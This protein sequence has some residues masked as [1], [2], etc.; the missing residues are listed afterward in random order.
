MRDHNSATKTLTKP[1]VRLLVPNS[2]RGLSTDATLLTECLQELGFIVVKQSVKAWSEEKTV[3]SHRYA[4]FKSLLP[5]SISHFL[6]SLQLSLHGFAAKKVDLQIHLESIAVEH[7]SAG[8]QN[9]LIPNQ[10]WVRPQHLCFLEHFEKILCKTEEALRIF[11]A[12][13]KNAHLIRFSNPLN[14]ENIRFVI[15]KN[16]YKRFLHVAGKN[17]KKGT[18]KI[19]EAWRNNPDWPTLYLVADNS[20]VNS[21]LPKNIKHWSNPNEEN[22]NRL[23]RLAGI[24]LAPSEVEGYGHVILEGMM[25]GSLVVTTDAAPMNESIQPD[26]GFLVPW[27][28]NEDC[29]LGQ[30]YFVET[31]AIEKSVNEILSMQT[32][33]LNDMVQRSVRWT[34]YNHILFIESLK[35]HM[36]E[37]TQQTYEE[38]LDPNRECVLE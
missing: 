15:D 32:E 25:S 29:H 19:I 24:V 5:D 14:N 28:R 12:H 22:L 2:G 18:Q 16:R 36:D 38:V 7:I 13:H 11:E 21:T 1:I 31:K 35:K 4:K 37:F 23:R 3:R 30:R 6:N 17:R 20:L 26:R 9:W 27:S 34:Q 33:E 8:K 10:E